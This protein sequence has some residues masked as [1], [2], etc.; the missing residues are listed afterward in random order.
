MSITNE[1]IVQKLCSDYQNGGLLLYQRYYKPLVVFANLQLSNFSDAED[2][3]QDVFLNFIKS[4]TYQKIDSNVLH[5]YLFRA[6]R[7]SCLNA[8]NRSVVELSDLDA[9]Y[10]EIMEEEV[11]TIDPQLIADI[12]I[13]ID[14]LPEKTRRVVKA[15]LIEG[16]KYKEVANEFDISVN[17][18]KTLFASG[19]KK[20]REQFPENVLIAFI[21]ML[22]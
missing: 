7:N 2:I 15:V 18:V 1:Q 21:F 3:V 22:S 19:L 5:T 6:V 4:R 10:F 8:L 11:T 12:N 17:T 14:N 13:A 16:Q 20:L 9:A